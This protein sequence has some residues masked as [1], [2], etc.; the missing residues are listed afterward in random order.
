MIDNVRPGDMAVRYGGEEMLVILPGCHIEGAV[1]V[2][3]RLRSAVERASLR[4]PS[5]PE[6]PGVTVS[7]G[8]AEM[9]EDACLEGF[10]TA[11]DQAL[12]RAKRDGRN[13]VR[14]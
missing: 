11:A 14:S 1:V 2:A 9:E 13:C 8:A 6:L 5:G 12:Y 3:E 4:L 10:I 7:I